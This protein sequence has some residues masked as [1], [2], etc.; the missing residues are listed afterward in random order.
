MKGTIG[1]IDVAK[2][3]TMWVS[4]MR[5][6]YDSNSTSNPQDNLYEDGSKILID[7]CMD[8]K[9]DQIIVLTKFLRPEATPEFQVEV[10]SFAEDKNEMSLLKLFNVSQILASHLSSH[11]TFDFTR[12]YYDQADNSFVILDANNHR[13]YWCNTFNFQVVEE[14]IHF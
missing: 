13:L 8:K 12:I 14:K 10:Y 7:V 1:I 9:H 4:I 5:P 11:D 2:S 6:Y 3:L